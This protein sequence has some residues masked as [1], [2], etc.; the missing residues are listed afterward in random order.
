M[1]DVAAR[2][3]GAVG[4]LVSFEED[5]ATVTVADALVLAADPLGPVQVRE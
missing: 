2:L 1:P 3:A 4:E 5:T